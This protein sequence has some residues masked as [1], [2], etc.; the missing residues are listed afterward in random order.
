MATVVV[1]AEPVN[2]DLPPTDTFHHHGLALLSLR[3]AAA[4]RTVRHPLVFFV[5]FFLRRPSRSEST[6]G[7]VHSTRCCVLRR[8]ATCILNPFKN[9]IDNKPEHCCSSAHGP[10]P[11]CLLCF[12]LRRPSRSESTEG[13]VHSTRCCVLRRPATCIL[14]V[15]LNKIAMKR[16]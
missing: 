7:S 9:K 4:Q 1:V 13:S 14:N 6:E 2:P 10:P 16:K 11:T 15:F 5:S 8:P 3:T 12:F